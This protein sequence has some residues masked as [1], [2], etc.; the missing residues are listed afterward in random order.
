MTTSISSAHFDALNAVLE[1][2]CEEFANGRCQSFEQRIAPGPIPEDEPN[3]MDRALTLAREAIERLQKPL[4][5]LVAMEGGLIQGGCA[6]VPVQLVTVD[7]DVEGVD[8]ARITLV[9]QDD[10]STAEGYVGGT[11]LDA[12]SGFIDRVLAAPATLKCD[13]CGEA[14][15]PSDPDETNWQQWKCPCC[16]SWNDNPGDGDEE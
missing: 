1:F 6:D 12:D 11:D 8:Q 10:G 3:E 7:Y 2:A 5:V 4:R 13:A 14:C 15:G 9:P 16:G